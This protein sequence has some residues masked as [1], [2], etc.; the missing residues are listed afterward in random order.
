MSIT[1]SDGHHFILLPHKKRKEIN[2]YKDRFWGDQHWLPTLQN[3]DIW[4][5]WT[6]NK[7]HW[8]K[9]PGINRTHAREIILFIWSLLICKNSG[10]LNMY[11]LPGLMSHSQTRAQHY[12][13][14]SNLKPS[15]SSSSF[16]GTTK[17]NILLVFP[18]IF[19]C[20]Y[21]DAMGFLKWRN[22]QESFMTNPLVHEGWKI[23]GET[24]F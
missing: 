6:L 15:P 7:I 8:C 3:R 17:S 22:P 18:F 14:V 16:S 2:P 1:N 4:W 12:S 11:T 5:I 13:I 10:F 20:G 23:G 24:S 21:N 19:L 9:I